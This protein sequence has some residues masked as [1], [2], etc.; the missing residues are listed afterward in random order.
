MYS[1][2]L[3]NLHCVNVDSTEEVPTTYLAVG[4]ILL[5]TRNIPTPY[6]LQTMNSIN[7]TT[8]IILYILTVMGLHG[9]ASKN[10]ERLIFLEFCKSI[11]DSI[12]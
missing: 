8:Y 10:L 7:N 6:R 1:L 9:A 5:H 2:F 12:G 11:F 3:E 4:G